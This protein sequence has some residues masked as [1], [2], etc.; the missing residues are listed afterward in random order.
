MKEHYLEG[1]TS[2]KTILGAAALTLGV[3]EICVGTL[4]LAGGIIFGLVILGLGASTFT[5]VPAIGLMTLGAGVSFVGS[6]V[7]VAGV[8]TAQ[9]GMNALNES[10]YPNT[11]M[12]GEKINT[13]LDNQS[14]PITTKKETELKDSFISTLT[15]ENNNLSK[16]TTPTKGHRQNLFGCFY[17]KKD[18]I[19]KET[20][21]SSLTKESESDSSFSPPSNKSNSL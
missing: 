14:T 7:I 3:S 19:S 1:E 5:L 4:T 10:L 13:Q 17:S 16:T 8:L 12:S 15:K 11:P 18:S 21:V 6:M 20:P 2:M 9:G